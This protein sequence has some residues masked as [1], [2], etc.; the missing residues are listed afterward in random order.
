VDL[1]HKD[2]T[3]LNNPEQYKE[4]EM[5]LTLYSNSASLRASSTLNSTHGALSH[6]LSRISSGLRV[7]EEADDAAG[8]ALVIKLRTQAQLGRQAF[9]S[10]NDGLSVIQTAEVASKE[11]VNILVR[12]RELAVQSSST[13]LVDGERSCINDEFDDLSNEVQWVAKA[14]EF[15]DIALSDGTNTSMTVQVGID[16]GTESQVTITL[17]NLTSSALGVATTDVDFSTASGS[18]TAIGII[19]TALERVNAIRAEYGLGSK[20]LSS[21]VDYMKADFD[22]LSVAES[23]DID[24]DYA[25]E[26]A[27]INRLRVMQQAVVIT[28]E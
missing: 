26:T 22:W 18:Q 10:V 15:N 8:F 5:A 2:S 12:M 9:R 11:V 6:T 27:E 20:R 17:G 24:A 14:T 3:T 1:F 25:H 19:D 13:T 7:V 16:G 21:L 4:A 23:Q 28:R